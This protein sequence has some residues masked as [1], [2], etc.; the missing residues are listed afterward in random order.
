MSTA[1]WLVR[2]STSSSSP[3]DTGGF[4]HKIQTCSCFV[5]SVPVVDYGRNSGG[6]FLSTT[7]TTTIDDWSLPFPNFTASSFGEDLLLTK[8]TRKHQHNKKQQQ[9]QPSFV[10]S[11]TGPPLVKSSMVVD[12]STTKE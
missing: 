1:R 3:Y 10:T 6:A 5:P 2:T 4:Y 8:T 12:Y 11:I 7:T 9:Q